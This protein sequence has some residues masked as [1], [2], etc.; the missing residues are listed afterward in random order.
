MIPKDCPKH[1]WALIE[2][3]QFLGPAMLHARS[4]AGMTILP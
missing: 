4:A 1:W 2:Q 3:G